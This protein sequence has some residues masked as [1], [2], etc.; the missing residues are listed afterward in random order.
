MWMNRHPGGVSS[1]GGVASAI[2]PVLT[3]STR[4]STIGSSAP[5]TG[6]R[7]RPR[8][9][10]ARSLKVRLMSADIVA[11]L[12]GG[13]VATLLQW[14]LK[15]V[16]Q[17]IVQDHLLLLL[18][19]VPLFLMG[20]VM[21]HLYQARANER[22]SEEW[23]NIVKAVGV[24]V[25]GLVLLAFVTQ[26]KGLSR[27]WVIALV[28]STTI[29]LIA[30]REIAR[31]IFTRLRQQGRLRRPIVIIGTDA[32]AVRLMHTF[33]RRPDLGYEVL[34]FV[35]PDDIG[36]RGG[37]NVLGTIDEVERI[38]EELDANGV[39][40]SPSSVHDHETNVLARRL[41][42]LGYHVAL[43]SN[44]RDIDMN[45]LR[46]QQFD[47]YAVLYIEPVIR[48]GWRPVA[49]RVFDVTVA[50]LILLLSLPILL[51]A[52]LATR[53]QG[54]GPLFFRQVRVGYGG[55]PFTMT[56]L[57]TMVV[58]AEARR[59]ELLDRNEMDGPLFKM[60]DD[61]RITPVGRVLRKLSIDE[62]PQLVSVVKGSMSMVGPRPALP[63]EAVHWDERVYERVRVLP[64]ITGMWQV[65]GRSD[66]SW[67]EYKRL[68]LYYVD[69]WSLT[70]D[71][72]I[73]AKTV[74]VVLSRRG[75]A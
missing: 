68:D 52:M 33:Q 43:S 47:G 10:S 22:P 17:F 27:F 55:Q 35:G 20:A 65:S 74:K 30:E 13:V 60:T 50:S 16:P 2:R 6:D 19:S 26:Y 41:T 39:V 14:V 40:V 37:V 7:R 1:A 51:L 70:H 53:L 11:L 15:P 8:V 73:C 24:Y 44:L 66:T 3:E 42:D 34:G 71:V 9:L 5:K 21:S 25:G 28:I 57:R 23:G 48:H 45:R 59:D 18:C 49:K 36:E 61:P 62:L 69:N 46:P 32:H 38:L 58:D 31:R 29:T 64:G 75:A 56:K 54:Q 63:D 67:E 72:R 4:A 12:V